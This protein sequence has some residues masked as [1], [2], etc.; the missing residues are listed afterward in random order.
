M[1]C[2]TWNIRGLNGLGKKIILKNR[3]LVDKHNILL[4]QETELELSHPPLLKK[5]ASIT[6]VT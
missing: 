4:I 5:I 3:I 2:T 6:I 1:N